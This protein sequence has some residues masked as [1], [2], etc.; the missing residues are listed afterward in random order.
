M[1]KP[2]SLKPISVEVG[3]VTVT[4]YRRKRQTTSGKSRITYEVADKKPNG[5]RRFKGFSTETAAR[6]EAERIARQMVSGNAV[7]A[8]MTNSEAEAYGRAVERLRP[9]GIDVD[10]AAANYAKAFEI[11]GADLI[12]EAARFYK[13][14]RADQITQRTVAQTVVELVTARK[15]RGKS[16]RY[17]GDLTARL[18]RFTNDFAADISAIT[19]PDVQNW[20]GKLKGSNQTVKNYRTVLFTL[21]KFAESNG[22]IIKGSNPV[23]ETDTITATGGAIEIYSP[24]EIIALLQGASRAAK[25]FLP[26]I[27][28]AAFAGLRS[29]EAE[30]L[31][32]SDIDLAGGYIHVASEKAKTRSRRLV[33][34]QPNL[35]AWLAS[36]SNLSGKVWKHGPNIIRAAR[37]ATV[38]AA[39]TPWKDNAMR[40]S[41]IS[42]RLA[43]TQDA[44]KVALEAGNSPAVVFKHYRE[45]VKP[46]TAKAWFAIAPDAPAN[47][48]PMAAAV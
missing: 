36:Y 9:V 12:L 28:L 21:F 48:V 46:E 27:A 15:A 10:I 18:K 45:L 38:E 24:A 33:P 30:R 19:G 3:N 47:V 43:D 44:A 23:A 34:I 25:D 11:L 22:Y 41:F 32:W 1:N 42:Y 37:A 29:A 35:S 13:R 20:L 14:H 26:I 40:H 7:A 31:E 17:V 16:A 6:L 5:Q 39:K 2:N 4:I 8:M